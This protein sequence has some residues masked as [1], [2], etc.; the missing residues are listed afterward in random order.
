VPWGIATVV[1][2][3][4]GAWLWVRS[5]AAWSSPEGALLWRFL[6]GVVLL[7]A[8]A[9]GIEGLYA[10]SPLFFVAGVL[11]VSLFVLK[12]LLS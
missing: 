8:F 3:V 4:V 9:T 7:G 6:G 1:L 2:G 5:R 10:I 12:A 11:G